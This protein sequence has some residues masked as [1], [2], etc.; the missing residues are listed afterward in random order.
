MALS[1]ILNGIMRVISDLSDATTE[2]V[3][4]GYKLDGRQYTEWSVAEI[5]EVL[6]A[7]ERRRNSGNGDSTMSKLISFS[8]DVMYPILQDRLAELEGTTEA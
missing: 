8:D 7:I 3:K 5:R 2:K 4:E 1:D 6:S